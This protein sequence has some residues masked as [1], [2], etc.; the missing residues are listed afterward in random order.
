[1]LNIFG[2]PVALGLL[3]ALAGLNLRTQARYVDQTA[4][5]AHSMW[6]C[7]AL[8]KRSSYKI[9]NALEHKSPRH[10]FIPIPTMSHSSRWKLPTWA[11]IVFWSPP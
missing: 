9:F 2:K 10:S 1:M 7:W 6:N 11:A 4:A 8:P 3:I 5:V